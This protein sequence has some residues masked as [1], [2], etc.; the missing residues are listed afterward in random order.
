MKGTG[1]MKKRFN[2]L[3]GYIPLISNKVKLEISTCLLILA[4][5]LCIVHPGI[6]SKIC[7]IAMLF[8]SIGDIALNSMPLEK[9][10][11]WL[12][13]TGAGFF[14]AAH[15]VYA[16]AYYLLI[17]D[18]YEF[19]NLGAIIGIVFIG[20]LFIGAIICVSIS[21][22]HLCTLMIL[23]FGIYILIIGFNFVTICSYSWS[24]KALSFLGALSFLISDFIIGTETVFAIKSDILR[25]LVWI[26]YPIGQFMI[27][28]CR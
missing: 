8:S 27:L 17:K 9:R 12:M 16:N 10:P 20:I 1:K 2:K 11:N 3:M 4:L 28:V 5:T 26:F 23:I 25:K 13:Y 7:F 15:L 22:E 14:M 18:S 19:F 24:A 6:D 21:K